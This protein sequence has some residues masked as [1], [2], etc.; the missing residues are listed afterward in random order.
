MSLPNDYSSSGSPMPSRP[1]QVAAPWGAGLSEADPAR[2][3]RGR[4]ALALAV[5]ALLGAC[6][7]A[8]VIGGT[9]APMEAA[10]GRVLGDTPSWYRSLVIGLTGSLLLWTLLGIAAIVLGVSD[11]AR[12]ADRS[13]AGRGG[14]GRAAAITA[15]AL[16]V[17]APGVA[18]GAFLLAMLLSTALL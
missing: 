3:P 12:S 6:L 18:F 13:G 15:I 17:I 10:H 4:T 7:A 9:V 1:G 8:L 16:A 11:L 5:A 2:P 14:R